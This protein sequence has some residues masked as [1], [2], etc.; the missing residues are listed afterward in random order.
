ML[1]SMEDAAELDVRVVGLRKRGAA[2]Q[3]LKHNSTMVLGRLWPLTGFPASR[4]GPR[5]H[6]LTVAAS[7]DAQRIVA[8]FPHRGD[9][10]SWPGGKRRG[11][12]DKGQPPAAHQSNTM[13]CEFKHEGNGEGAV[14][15]V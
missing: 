2:K 9:A 6:I 13:V 11:D 12:E 7:T 15:E 14:F 4:G 5:P 1:V 3:S 10:A 8:N